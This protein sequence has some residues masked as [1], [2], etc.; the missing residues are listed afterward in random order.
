MA[1]PASPLPLTVWH[2]PG[3]DPVDPT[4]W[5]WQE[6][7]SDVRADQGVQ[8]Q[9]G[10]TDEGSQV[11][12]SRVRLNLDNRTGNYSPRNPLGTNFGTLGKGTPIQARVRRILDTFT[13]TTSGGWGTEPD[14]GLAWSHSSASSWTTNGSS[15]LITHA[16]ANFAAFAILFDAA[17]DDVDITHTAS[18]PAV[19]TGAAWVHATIVRYADG[20]NYYLVHTEFATG[21]SVSVKIVR[22]L[23][24]SEIDLQSITA[25]GVT[26]TGGT[27]IATRVQAI[28]ST[29]RI[30]VWQASGSEPAAWSAQV[31][32]STVTGQSTGLY[33]WRVS[34]NTNAGSVTCTI[35]N[36]AMSAIRSTTPVPE[37][38]VRWDKSGNDVT[39][40]VAG[41]GIL[42]R[43]AQGQAAQRSPLYRQ[44]IA[45]SPHGYWPLEDGSNATVG[46]SAVANG[47]PA[48]QAEAS[49]GSTEAPGGASASV[50]L[51]SFSNN[52]R[53]TGGINN[54]PATATGYAGMALFK[55]GSVPGADRDLIRFF[56]TGRVWRWQIQ[57]GTT[58]FVIN[59]VDIDGASVVSTSVLHLIDATSWF[60]LQL[61]TEEVGGNVNWVLLWHQV[62]TAGFL[63]HSGSYAGTADRITA[64][65]ATAP[66]DN[67]Q[68]CHVWLG[69]NTLPFVDTTFLAVAAG[70]AGEKAGDRLVRLCADEGIPLVVLGDTADTPPMGVQPMASFLELARECE[71][72]DQGILHERGAGLGYRTRRA[73][74]N[75]T[76]VMALDFDQGHIAEPPEPVD[77]DQRLR[78]RVRL[79]RSGGSEATAQDADSITASGL[80]ADEATVNLQLDSHLEDHAS[81][82][83]HLGTFDELRWPS[84]ELD[85][86]RNPSLIADWCKVRIGSRITIANPPTAVAGDSLDLLV[87]GW[88]ETLTNYTWRVVLACS[89]AKAWDTGIYFDLDRRYDSATT[90]TA[91]T[92]PTGTV[93][94]TGVSL[95]IS[96]TRK[97]QAWS[98]TAVPY[99][100]NIAGELVT[101]TAMTSPVF[102]GGVYTQTAT[103]TRGTGGLVKSHSTGEQVRLAYPA[104]YAL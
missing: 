10:R 15:G 92:L 90:T 97:R 66:V 37:W 44:L 56:G 16:S 2:A 8:L 47:R 62:G 4:T 55:L 33:E 35:D 63:S 72:A 102:S 9:A 40:P 70:Y 58:G 42:S 3:G 25:S 81:W 73:R 100:W 7:T 80:Y 49:F 1:F 46:A 79:K 13:R 43:L 101:V 93:G 77:D 68:I 69:P 26:Y 89:P 57:I 54:P 88:T 52:S 34:G 82:R 104:R 18:V 71:A 48:T 99:V 91:G 38:P 29:L 76:A 32:D 24:G 23:N 53:I 51:T 14:S 86:A 28:G 103:I 74:M 83:L 65:T 45:Q 12:A 17:A 22:R 19:M 75:T 87:E 36:F 96:T 98:T 59:A 84:I 31:Q 50:T 30:K 6:I 21:G 94:Q 67:T 61:E 85:L 60:A 64:W 39:A 20:D 27:Q 78:N 41:A 5:Q 11:G 95:A